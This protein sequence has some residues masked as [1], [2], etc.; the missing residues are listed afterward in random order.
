MRVGL[1]SDIHGNRWA[2]EAVLDHAAGQRVDEIWNLGDILSGPLDVAGTADLLMRLSLPT[3]R[4]NTERQLLACA[5]S[6]G[7]PSDQF[8]FE[9]C[10]P[11]HRAWLASLPET[12]LRGDI[13]LCHGTPSS[14]EDPL[15]ET[16]EAERLRLATPEEIEARVP[17]AA[18]GLVVCGHTH[19][20]RVVRMEGGRLIVNPGSIGLQAYDHDQPSLHYVDN[21]S[22]HA[23]YAI[24]EQV[25]EALGA[26]QVSQFRI[27]YDWQSAAACAAKHGRPEWAYALRT[28]V[29]MRQL[30]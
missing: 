17:A 3:I 10:E 23:S 30:S 21:G 13:L 14:D 6:P 26:W 12:L 19:V 16:V 4:G 29:A 20:A 8:A 18:P 27:A 5:E 2:L 9:R 28:G 15:L 7:T 25:G 11:R 24:V 1:L 22:P